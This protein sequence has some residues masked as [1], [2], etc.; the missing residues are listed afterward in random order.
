MTNAIRQPTAERHTDG[1]CD[2]GTDHRHGECLALQ[3]RSDHVT[4]VATDD[5]PSKSGGRSGKETCGKDE[6]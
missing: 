2:R 4:G 6:V 5:T 3:M 1:E